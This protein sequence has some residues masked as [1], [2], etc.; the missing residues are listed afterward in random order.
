VYR[1]VEITGL[2]GGSDRGEA[3]MSSATGPKRPQHPG[4][5]ACARACVHLVCISSR[6]GRFAVPCQLTDYDLPLCCARC[7]APPTSTRFVVPEKPKSIG[8]RRRRTRRPT[9]VRFRSLRPRP[10]RAALLRCDAMRCC[11]FRRD[12]VDPGACGLVLLTLGA[13]R[14]SGDMCVPDQPVVLLQVAEQMKVV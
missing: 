8:L 11:L 7:D 12:T 6:P 13:V 10:R 1:T 14:R 4:V 2:E 5:C 3:M 9:Q